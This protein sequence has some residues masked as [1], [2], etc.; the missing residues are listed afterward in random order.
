[1]LN[2]HGNDITTLWCR[3]RKILCSITYDVR[4]LKPLLLKNPTDKHILLAFNRQSRIV[5]YH[6]SKQTN[7]RF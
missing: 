7:T 6:F 2:S 5:S 4:Q 1:M 3:V